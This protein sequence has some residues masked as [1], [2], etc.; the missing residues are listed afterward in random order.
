MSQIEFDENVARAL[1]RMYMTPD[2]VGQRS[3]FLRAVA[4]REGERA[5][6]VGVG[7]GLLVHD[8]AKI[9]GEKGRVAGVDASDAMVGISEKRCA[10]LGWTDFHQADATALP[11]D[12]ASFDVVTSSQ[13]YE[14]VAD[15]EG[16]LTEVHRVLRPG[17]RVFILDTDWDSVVWRTR[18]RARMRRVM[19]AWDGHLHDPHLPARLGAL[20]EGAGLQVT[21]REVIPI[22]NPSLHPHCYSFGILAAIQGFVAASGEVEAD[23]AQA[24]ADELRALGESGEYFFS[25]NRYV[26]G[27]LRA[28]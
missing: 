11:F 2:V 5:L 9:V 7:P 12:D 1:E 20:L 13:V 19:D 15:M 27:A 4:L 23:E 21:H 6:D 10:D 3:D 26:F 16:A 18:D 24:W 14:Y 25:I 8:M 28:G 17:G 22:V